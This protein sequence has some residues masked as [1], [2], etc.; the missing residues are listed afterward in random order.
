MCNAL[1]SA[2]ELQN[3]VYS[4]V[5]RLFRLMR[6]ISPVNRLFCR[7]VT[8]VLSTRTTRSIGQ[9]IA[10]A[11]LFFHWTTL[12]VQTTQLLIRTTCKT[13]FSSSIKSAVLDIRDR[14]YLLVYI[15]RKLKTRFEKIGQRLFYKG[16]RL[17]SFLY[18][19]ATF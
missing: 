3:K 11:P 2:H 9:L 6:C 15:V 12:C 16:K 1:A 10:A 19:F 17:L 4:C 18:L 7:V 13:Y 8:I 14:L 5:P